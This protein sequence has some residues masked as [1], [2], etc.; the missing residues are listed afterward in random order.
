MLT[1]PC[2]K[3]ELMRKLYLFLTAALL[4]C[5]S[6]A[7]ALLIAT[8]GETEFNSDDYSGKYPNLY[9][10]YF[11]ISASSEGTPAV[12]QNDFKVEGWAKYPSGTIDLNGHAISA[13][14]IVFG[15]QDSQLNIIGNGYIVSG[16]TDAGAIFLY[17]ASEDKANYSVLTIGKDV[18][19][20][21]PNGNGICIFGYNY[22]TAP[23]C[24]NAYGVKV[25]V[26]G[27]ILAK[28]YGITTNGNI[29]GAGTNV[30]QINVASTAK[31]QGV[32]NE[33]WT[34]TSNSCGT[35]LVNGLYCS[36]YAAG[37]GVWNIQGELTA[38]TPIYAKSGTI[39]VDGAKI[40][41]IGNYYE[42]APNGN[43]SCTTGD[44][45]IMDSH[46]SYRGD[47]VLNVI[48][49]S[50]LVSDNGYAVHE[51][52][53]KMDDTKS[54]GLTL[55]NSSF[56]G[57]KG[58]VKLSDEFAKALVDGSTA[59]G[60]WTLNA[61]TSGKYTAKPEVVADGYEVVEVSDSYPF[62][63]SVVAKTATSYTT[64][65]PAEDTYE[66]YTVTRGKEL[67]IK[68]GK[69]V[70]IGKLTIGD[71]ASYP[72]RVRVEAG[73][74]LI[75]GDIVFNN[76]KGA[77]S[78]LLEAN[79]EHGTGVLLFN[80]NKIVQPLGSVDL[81]AKCR[82]IDMDNKVY[83]FQHFGIPMFSEGSDIEK[84]AQVAYATW[85]LRNGWQKTSK[86]V[87]LSNGPW[88]GANFTANTPF[89]GSILKFTGNLVGNVDAQF[90]IASSEYGYKCFANSYTAPMSMAEYIMA[91]KDVSGFDGTIWVYDTDAR[92][93][94]QYVYA[95][96]A[97]DEIGIAP[98]QAFFMSH[99]S[100]TNDAFTVG[101]NE[102]VK[103]FYTEVGSKKAG[104][105]TVENKG[106]ITISD[107]NS[108]ATLSLYE[109]DGFSDEF[110]WGYDGYQ[111]ETGDIMI[112]V[113][114]SDKNYSSF[115]T[116]SFEG[117]EITIVS[118]A[119]TEIT[120]SFSKLGGKAFKLIDKASGAEVEVSDGGTYTF[121]IAPNSTIVRF[122]LGEGEVSANEADADAVKIWV[123]EN[124][125]NIA[126]D[127]EG[128]AIEVINLA[129]VK[130]LSATATG[131]AVQTISLSG[132]AS[133]AYIVKAGETTVK[134][135][136]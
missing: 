65:T 66:E 132:I 41:A 99:L 31:I 114:L 78:L 11:A 70:T 37:Y 126:G 72:A 125:L 118:Q 120:M 13:D 91:A 107:G 24:Y 93:F 103:D 76:N 115:A 58:T 123:A 71:E 79:G 2:K 26:E 39:T 127:A 82:A 23:D 60:N 69:K 113:A 30:P 57:A 95:E 6:S 29:R 25:T 104:D 45:I 129:G 27:T 68:Y 73:G 50:E 43:G 3:K 106:K 12:I 108:N 89:A 14:G 51:A 94:N 28:S 64:E 20:S 33:E 134:V 130:V 96:A 44:A 100:S 5:C 84:N 101:Y 1:P 83:S 42:P 49:N 81:Y 36:I 87:V 116:N 59:S 97:E 56:A 117:K 19:I 15:V 62:L 16:N 7:N 10:L 63:Y 61:V 98:M 47:V 52:L 86:D 136:K 22:P 17:G 35:V 38:S 67:V 21:A 131:E 119:A 133:G 92:G 80:D 48:G 109:G 112:Y 122:K 74:V 124:S 88:S 4:L 46:Q 53:T 110:D 105:A 128:D 75:V 32:N 111:M 121:T 40:H 9:A 85:N 135:I 90:E 102:S 77:E 55:E 18:T 34:L 8:V 54:I